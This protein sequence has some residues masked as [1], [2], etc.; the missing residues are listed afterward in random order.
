MEEIKKAMSEA[1]KVNGSVGDVVLVREA[2][3]G[4]I[5][6]ADE[7]WVCDAVRII[8]NTGEVGKMYWDF[9]DMENYNDIEDAS[10]FDW[11]KAKEDDF[12]VFETFDLSDNDERAE[13]LKE[14]K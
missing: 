10:D 3:H 11:D 12:E 2:Y 14:L 13:F 5:P 4:C 8:G 7:T 9:S 1:K 6:G